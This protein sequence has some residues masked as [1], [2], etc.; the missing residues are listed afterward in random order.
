MHK[1]PYHSPVRFYRSLDDLLDS[2]N[3][4]NL[5][6]FGSKNP[7]PLEVGEYHRFLIPNYENEVD[8][9]ELTLWIGDVQISSQFAINDGRLYR[10]SFICHDSIQG[11]FEI[12][13]DNGETLFYSNCVR[14]IDSD[15]DG[16]KYVRVATKCYFN[17]LGYQF[18]QSDYDWFVTNLPAYDYGLYL[19]DSEYTTERTGTG[20]TLEI[21]DSFID[22]VATLN[23]IGEGDCNVM[24][25]IL[26]SVLNN[27]FYI[28]GT[29][30]TIK[31]KP[32]IDDL[33]I[34]GKMKF[35]YNKDKYGMYI[36]I[37]ESEIFS[38][39]FR[40]VLGDGNRNIVY[41]Y[42]YNYV[43]PTK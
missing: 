18:S 10:V 33:M 41:G 24:N 3:S 2:T 16:R 17:R 21:Q 35:A 12:K 40:S 43:I 25:F 19:I 31:D 38:D 20:K 9:T 22:E 27:E 13:K 30:R 29:K 34:V 7:Y 15:A 14:F 11:R 6:Y 23:F 26:F 28:N 8:S 37:N 36:Q 42:N 4:Q 1:Y 32:E 39:A 5:Q